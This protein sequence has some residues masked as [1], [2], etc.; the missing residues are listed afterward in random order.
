MFKF[1]ILCDTAQGTTVLL[2]H[3]ITVCVLSDLSVSS[4]L[5]EVDVDDDDDDDDDKA[6]TTTS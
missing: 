4:G 3:A 2:C 6:D 5:M 1:H